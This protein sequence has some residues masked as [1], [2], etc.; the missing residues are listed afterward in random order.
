MSNFYEKLMSN[1]FYKEAST[2][3]DLGMTKDGVRELLDKSFT[4]E[5]MESLAE[6]LGLAD[7]FFE[8]EAEEEVDLEMNLQKEAEDEEEKKEEP[9]TDKK[10]DTEE[11][12][13]DE[14]SD[15]KAKKETEEPTE[16][17]EKEA[18]EEAFDVSKMASMIAEMQEKVASISEELAGIA[19]QFPAEEK[20]AEA[21]SEDMDKKAEE[22]AIMIKEAYDQAAAQLQENGYTLSDFV[23]SKVANED[24][25]ALIVDTAEKLAYIQGS[26]PLMEADVIISKITDQLQ[27]T[28]E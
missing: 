9:E 2:G 14:S 26:N 6:E 4:N 7:L 15:D 12:S 18:E 8:K 10:D 28:E 5:Q 21:E 13:D 24:M 3:A 1:N 19:A 23:M 17:P 27:E 20:E 25:A 22:E 11:E 16:E